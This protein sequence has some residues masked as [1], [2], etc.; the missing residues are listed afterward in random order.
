[1]PVVIFILLN[2]CVAI[3]QDWWTIPR[4]ETPTHFIYVASSE[5]KG[6][7][8]ELKERAFM[9]AATMIVR[10]HFGT[11]IEAQES[12]IE[13]TGD[14][15]FQF[16]TKIKSDSMILKGLKLT[17]LKILGQG[18]LTRVLVRVEISRED[19]LQAI[20]RQDRHEAE[21]IYNRGK[22]KN[23]ILVK[24]TPPGALIQITGKDKNYFVQGHGDAKFYLPSGSYALSIS[25][26]GYERELSQFEILNQDVEENFELKPILGKFR[27]ETYPKDATI[28]TI[29]PIKGK[30]PFYLSPNKKVRFRVSHPDYFEQEFE[31]SITGDG[32]FTKKISLQARPSNI[33]IFVNP[34]PD[35]LS[36]NNRHYE[37]GQ[38]VSTD[39]E[40]LHVVIEK[41]GYERVEKTIR[42]GPNRHYPDEYINLTPEKPSA[43]FKWPS[44]PTLPSFNLLREGPLKKRWE[45]NPY[46]QL[47]GR[48]YFSIVPVSFFIEK[49]YLSGGLS[50]N[51]IDSYDDNGERS[52]QK[53]ISDFSL[54]FR[55]LLGNFESV[56]PYLVLTSG[57][58]QI[59]Q[60]ED[61]LETT[62]NSE[63][64]FS[65][66]G[67]G[68][69]LRIYYS[70]SASIHAEMIQINKELSEGQN[71]KI[72]EPQKSTEIKAI[73]GLGWEF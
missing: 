59:N 40:E 66:Y 61:D 28:S 57:S 69:G 21:N 58:Y 50:Y 44:F 62:K 15:R 45:Y 5:G 71:L 47:D 22:G 65:Y 11:T 68:G 12:M 33:R 34:G 51:Y 4:E 39:E 46:V 25:E 20:K 1:M 72:D 29:T 43:P 63:M 70:N 52:L 2:S 26:N 13:D 23:F 31:Y 37:S 9:A 35:L 32:E 67:L 6:S 18:D 55:L 42:I 24:T 64:K 54:N 19:L 41:D 14:S 73:I 49:G 56:V 8:E 17:D 48:G 30:N 10:E 36:I 53:S 38:R 3:S 16:L 7:L 27:I 60:T